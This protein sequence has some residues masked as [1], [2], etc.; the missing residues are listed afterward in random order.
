[1][2]IKYNTAHWG[3]TIYHRV[4]QFYNR[5]QQFFIGLSNFSPRL[6]INAG[7]NLKYGVTL[8]PSGAGVVGHLFCGKKRNQLIKRI[9]W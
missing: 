4:T 9:R 6:Q 7:A 5:V 1:M 3:S 8:V 2:R